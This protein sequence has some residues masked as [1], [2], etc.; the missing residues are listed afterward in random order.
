MITNG[1]EGKNKN[2]AKVIFIT[3]NEN[4]PNTTNSSS[5]STRTGELFV[6]TQLNH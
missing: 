1:Q 3:C 2:E 6:V 4:N 5:C